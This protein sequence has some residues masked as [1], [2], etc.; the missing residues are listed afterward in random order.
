MMGRDKL[1]AEGGLPQTKMIPSWHF[2]IRTLTMT[3]P[4]HKHIAW[5]T[6]IQK[7]ICTNKTTKW[8]LEST[9]RWMGHASFVIPWVYH[10]LSR[11]QN[12]LA[13]SCNRRTIKIINKCAKDLDL[14]RRIL[15]KAQKGIDTNLLAFKAQDWV[16]YLDSCPAGLGSYSN[17][18][19]VLRFKVPDKLLSMQRIICWNILQQSSL[20]GLT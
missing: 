17:Q 10:F 2:N 6:K 12:L 1:K 4:K 7:M 9:I 19:F 16:Y 5:S 15:D 14:M 13:C 3:L 8:D 11:L 20:P 18:G